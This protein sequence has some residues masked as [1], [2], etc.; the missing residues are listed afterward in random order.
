MSKAR[1]TAGV[2][3]PLFNEAENV[4]ALCAELREVAA[5]D[6][7]VTEMILVDDGST[8]ATL[9]KC[10][11][12]CAKDSRFTVISLRRN[13]GQTPALSAGFDLATSDVIVPMD[14]DLQFD[15]HD[16][17]ALLNKVEEGYD[18]V[19]GWRQRRKDPFFS[20]RVPSWMAN[21]IISWI[22]G[23]RLHDHGCTMKA[24]KRDLLK[25]IRLYGEMHR[26]IPAL[27]SWMGI[28]LAEIPVRHRPRRAGAS[29]YGLSRIVRVI[30][31]LI[32]VKFLLDYSTSPI[33][34]FGK[35][36]LVSIFFAF[37][38][39]VEVIVLKLRTP[40]VAMNRNPILILSVLLVLVGIQLISMG[41][42]GELQIRTYYESQKKPI[43]AIREVFRAKS[44]QELTA[45]SAKDAK[46]DSVG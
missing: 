21:K 11:E 2:V 1:V 13:F 39:L 41:L 24:Y 10:K 20:R 16:I 31:D 3:V 14:G 23:V 12:E 44:G 18:V 4:A 45:K 33:Q 6:P 17:P 7:R 28:T 9:A 43:Y 40:S 34:V 5:S 37:L 30:L 22:T 46:N 25:D 38:A 15:A 19:S 42:L 32:N 26:F 29:K 27:A 36:G 35:L 8:D